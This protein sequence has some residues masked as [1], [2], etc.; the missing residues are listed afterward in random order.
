MATPVQIQHQQ[1]KAKN[2]QAILFFQLGDFYELF[3]EDAQVGAR[4]LGINLTARHKGTDN[5]MPMCGFP[6]HSAQKY[7]EC[8]VDNG[9]RVAIADQIEDENGKITRQ[10]TRVVSAGTSL[11]EGNLEPE[12]NSFLVAIDTHQTQKSTLFALAVIDVST[13]D[14]RTTNFTT[15]ADF[16]DELYKLNPR[17]ILLPSKIFAQESFCQKL[18][19][20]LL[21]PR[22]KVVEKSAKKLLLEHFNIKSLD[23]FGLEEMA[24]QIEVSALV[25]AFLKE[26]QNESLDHIQKIVR[27][28]TSQTMVLDRQ[29]M[30]HLE[31]FATLDPNQKKGALIDVFE[32]PFTA[33]GNRQ[34]RH[35]IAHPLLDE[36]AIK[37]R[38]DAVEVFTKN[39][40]LRENL[41]T[42]L[43]QIFDIERLLA[44]LAVNRGNAKDLVFLGKTLQVFPTLAEILSQS[45]FE[46][47]KNQAPKFAGL[48]KIS[49]KLTQG[50]VDNPPNEITAGG[51]FQL[52][53]DKKLDEL[54]TL[55]QDTESWLNN[56]L[57]QKKQESGIEKLRIKFS[58]NFGFCLETSKVAASK[59]PASWT[60]RQTLVN[61]ER[62]TTPELAEYETRV[63]NAESEA[64]ALE[65]QL[66]LDLRAEVLTHTHQLQQAAA[67]IAHIDTA[68]SLAR[69]ALKWKWTKPTIKTES[70][71]FMVQNGRHPVVEQIGTQ[72]FIA[73]SL[74]MKQDGSRFHLITGPNMAGKSTFLRQNALI[75]LLAQIGSFVPAEKVTMGTFDRIFTR[76][77]ASDNLAAGKSTFFVEMSET[78]RILNAATQKS[79]VILD[80][81]GRG[82]STFDG[83]SLAWAITEYLHNTVQAKT[84]FATHYHEMIDCVA[85]LSGGENFHVAV[86]QT[87]D[88]IIFLRKIV[89]GG[90][91]DSFGIEVAAS[92]GFPHS[93]IK[94]SKQILQDLETNNQNTQP[95]LFSQPT[96]KTETPTVSAVEERLDNLDVND[97]SPR[98]ALEILYELKNL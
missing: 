65:H 88:E 95:N 87:K 89:P 79:F 63:L 11:E 37:K 21:T 93:V 46:W 19:D 60:R 59:A 5:E 68:V 80:E 61:A 25:I 57:E 15:E 33:L 58:K 54:L 48:E 76:V 75:I 28:S 43:K 77:G 22:P 34:L 70:N 31:I 71:E 51:M 23:S 78:A 81:I 91:S 14:F 86:N 45:D 35:Q 9:Y 13:G 62:F 44:R 30:T 72:T 90:V 2:P 32:K 92:T 47:L 8:L 83:I 64:F 39:F 42:A 41:E 52:G 50:L 27:Y 20:C 26:T 56:F 49:Q 7:L 36:T 29:T 53:Y 85:S 84:I 66:F 97:I 73:N 12:K 74:Q 69:T 67:A 3:M 24:L 1:L 16:L 82:T 55:K 98:E 17:E 40:Y 10:I 4:V 18:P 38:L 94:R 96:T 6:K